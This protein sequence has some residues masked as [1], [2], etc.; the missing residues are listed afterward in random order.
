MAEQRPERPS[1]KPG[2]PG[3]GN[4][5]FKFRNGLLGWLLFIGLA[6]ML[7]MLVQ[8]TRD[9]ATTI[10]QNEFWSRYEAGKVSTVVV[11]DPEVTGKFRDMEE[12]PAGNKPAIQNFKV[13]FPTGYLSAQGMNR[14][15]D[16][17]PA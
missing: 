5:T 2:R 14:L 12:I 17:A 13:V 1:R 8:H 4:G 11:E 9:N 6:V 10:S 15:L 3:A 16:K 7:V